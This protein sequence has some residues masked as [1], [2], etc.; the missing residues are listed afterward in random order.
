MNWIKT[1]DQLPPERKY[2][3]GRYNGGNW[4]DNDDPDGVNVVIVKIIKGGISLKDRQLMKAGV[5]PDPLV[6][7]RRPDN[8][9]GWISSFT[10]RSAFMYREDEQYG[11]KLLYSWRGRGISFRGDEISEW[12]FIP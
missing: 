4:I 9:G 10:K 1:K 5:I 2:V 3:L 11:N 7:T 6:E 8:F 12:A